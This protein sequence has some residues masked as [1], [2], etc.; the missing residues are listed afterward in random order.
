MA[1]LDLANIPSNINTYERLAVWVTQALQSSSNGVSVTVQNGAGA[2]P[3]AQVQ[4]GT[5]AD[6]VERFI[7]SAYLPVDSNELNSPTEKTWM[8]T[9][10]I[11]NAAPHTN[12]LSN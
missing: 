2:L 12:F 5:T 4:V 3:I 6:G 11:S 7:L 10:D 8:A 1:A 9:Q